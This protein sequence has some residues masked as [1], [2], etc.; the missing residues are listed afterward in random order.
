MTDLTRHL[1]VTNSQ[2]WAACDNYFCSAVTFFYFYST[3]IF[4]HFC[5]AGTF[6][7][8][9]ICL[10]LFAIKP[11]SAYY[12]IDITPSKLK[13]QSSENLQ[14]IP[15]YTHTIFVP[16]F[17]FHWDL[18]PFLFCWAHFPFLFCL[19]LFALCTHLGHNLIDVTLDISLHGGQVNSLVSSLPFLR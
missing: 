6:F 11:H 9:L 7:P 18:F 10:G 1:L 13:H 2:A 14:D 3:G 5:A 16:L 8:F 15:F 4:F 17:L 12:L 19:D